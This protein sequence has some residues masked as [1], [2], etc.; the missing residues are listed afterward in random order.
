MKEE[1]EEAE[2]GSPF[3]VGRL[4]KPELQIPILE[5]LENNSDIFTS[6]LPKGAPSVRIGHE[7]RVN[8]VEK[9]PPIHK[10]LFKLSPIELEESKQLI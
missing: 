5:A 10:R 8:L 3:D 9:T 1:T 4:Y 2:S 6:E 7:L